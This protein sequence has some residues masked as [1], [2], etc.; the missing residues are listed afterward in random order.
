MTKEFDSVLI[1]TLLKAINVAMMTFAK[2]DLKAVKLWA[3]IAQRLVN[4]EEDIKKYTGKT[5]AILDHFLL[6]ASRIQ[7]GLT[8]LED[9]IKDLTEIR[10]KLLSSD[11]GPTYAGVPYN[12]E[13]DE[14]DIKKDLIE[15]RKK[16][17]SALF[18]K[19]LSSDTGPTYAGA[20]YNQEEDEEAIKNAL[21]KLDKKKQEY[22][23]TTKENLK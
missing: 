10:K 3:N 9:G 8:G 22:S 1:E 7:I 6:A 19:L 14:E 21:K 16:R 11:T 17:F 13:R 2:N 18:K 4:N 20:P 15:I 5:N 12:Q 23:D